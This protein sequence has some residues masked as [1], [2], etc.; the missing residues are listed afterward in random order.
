[1]H[2]H[3]RHAR[4]VNLSPGQGAVRPRAVSALERTC[5]AVLALHSCIEAFGTLFLTPPDV[6]HSHDA[7]RC[8]AVARV[9]TCHA[10]MLETWVSY[11]ESVTPLGNASFDASFDV[12]CT[13]SPREIWG[14]VR[15]PKSKRQFHVRFPSFR[16]D[17]GHAWQV[18]DMTAR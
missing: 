2:A 6:C 13:W 3:V 16:C 1:M 5:G 12:F 10:T 15:T 4:G 8:C 7:C 9:R 18:R 14:L 17:G 11:G